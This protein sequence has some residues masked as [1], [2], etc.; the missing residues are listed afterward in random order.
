LKNILIIFIIIIILINYKGGVKMEDSKEEEN[1]KK[2]EKLA[3]RENGPWWLW[4]PPWGF[5]EDFENLRRSM[6]RP[7]FWP[8]SRIGSLT[9]AWPEH[10]R[11]RLAQITNR[12]PLLDIKDTGDEL[13]I[14]AEMPGISKENI[15]IQLTENSIQICG[16]VKTV[17]KDPDEG[18]IR[19]ERVYTTCARQMPLPAEII[20]GEADATLKDGILQIKLPKKKPTPKDK[21]H[22]LKIK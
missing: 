16:E 17:E 21:T 13:L 2:S 19:Q 4:D 11:S 14:E 5:D 18:Y 8:R 6:E 9:W 10:F 20:P 1:K 7:L 15:D 22:S 12:T 3:K